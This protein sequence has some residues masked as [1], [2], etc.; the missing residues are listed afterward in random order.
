VVVATAEQSGAGRRAERGGVEAGV[1]E[2]RAG[3]RLGDRGLAGTPKGAGGG[4]TDV[5]EQDDE[6][7][8]GSRGRAQRLGD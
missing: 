6:D 8:G 5:V 1:L 3:Q 4:E 2:P 7:V